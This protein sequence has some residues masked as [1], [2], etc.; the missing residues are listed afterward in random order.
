MSGTVGKTLINQFL[1][2]ELALKKYSAAQD[3]AKLEQVN[4]LLIKTVGQYGKGSS[5]AERKA[6]KRLGEAHQRTLA[7]LLE[8]KQELAEKM[9]RLQEHK[10]GLNAYQLTELSSDSDSAGK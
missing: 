9:K 2:L 4:A 1:K 7:N 8:T 10:E 3:F 6:F 5:A